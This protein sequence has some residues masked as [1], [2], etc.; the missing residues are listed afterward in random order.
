M[1]VLNMITVKCTYENGDQIT[2]RIN[3]TFEEA[4]RYFLGKTF[5]IGT[6]EDNLQKCV[7]VEMVK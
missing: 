1:E 7:K 6:I 2:T 5:N 3:T 4:K